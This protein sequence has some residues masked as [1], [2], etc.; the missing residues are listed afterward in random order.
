MP[1]GRTNPCFQ[2]HI[3]TPGK[4]I[5]KQRFMSIQKA[6]Y[7]RRYSPLFRFI[8]GFTFFHRKLTDIKTDITSFH[9]A[10]IEHTGF[11]LQ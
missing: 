1:I 7:T 4:R 6:L 3:D 5:V 11:H 9:R 8:V 10:D 2:P